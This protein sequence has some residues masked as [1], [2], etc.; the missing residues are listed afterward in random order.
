MFV[1]PASRSDSNPFFIPERIVT[2]GQWLVALFNARVLKHSEAAKIFKT[3]SVK[4]GIAATCVLIALGTAILLSRR[5]R[6]AQVQPSHVP[7]PPA[8]LPL[9]APVT[10][11]PALPVVKK[12]S[13]LQ[14]QL[15][16]L[17]TKAEAG[18]PSAKLDLARFL[19][20]HSKEFD[21]DHKQT[22]DWYKKAANGYQT[23]LSQEEKWAVFAA[24]KRMRQVYELGEFGEEQNIEKAIHYYGEEKNIRFEEAVKRYHTEDDNILSHKENAPG[25]LQLAQFYARRGD[26]FWYVAKK[27]FK[28]TVQCKLNETDFKER[29]AHV[30]AVRTAAYWLSQYWE[31]RTF[32]TAHAK[33]YAWNYYKL[34]ASLGHP[35]ALQK[36]ELNRCGKEDVDFMLKIAHF[37]ARGM[38]VA[39][40][41]S[42]ARHW[43]EQAFRLE[44]KEAAFWLG[45]FFREGLFD[46]KE[47]NIIQSWFDPN[48]EFNEGQALYWYQ[49][50]EKG[51]IVKATP[52][53]VKLLQFF[54]NEKGY[55]KAQ[56]ELAIRYTQNNQGVSQNFIE[57]RDLCVRAAVSGDSDAAYLL[58]TFYET[59]QPGIDQHPDSAWGWYNKAIDNAK[60]PLQAWEFSQAYTKVCKLADSG[61]VSY[62]RALAERLIGGK[63]V[64]KSAY[65]AIGWYEKASQQGDATASLTLANIYRDGIAPECPPEPTKALGPYD[66]AIKQGSVDASYELGKLLFEGKL[67]SFGN[68]LVQPN[69]KL[70]Q[71]HFERAAAQNHPKAIQFLKDKMQVVQ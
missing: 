41:S 4:Y 37:Y 1:R 6:P 12:D 21:S 34:A 66:R 9:N 7:V 28:A 23:Y 63:G 8:A 47:F 30:E 18:Q 15:L 11:T 42:Q 39:A 32:E 45:E 2:D 68:T 25:I 64:N 71:K 38:H 50:A 20:T 33:S 70:A 35:E 17:Q 54:A 62:K 3:T 49:E 51:G 48:T 56:R 29:P 55:P 69:P 44:C 40:S 43:L 14:T 10:T 13:E 58:G 31:P 60:L 22:L 5:N 59:G 52:E 57:A 19:E 26:D 36:L 46:R 53:I 65:E 16:Q 61:P 24:C 67:D 27:G